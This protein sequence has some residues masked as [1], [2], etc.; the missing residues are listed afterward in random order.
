MTRE[1]FEEWLSENAANE[2]LTTDSGK[3]YL[4]DREAAAAHLR[5]TYHLPEIADPYGYIRV[6]SDAFDP[7]VLHYPDE[8]YE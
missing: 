4:T 1:R 3:Q 2:W 7:T 6:I 8:Y 5:E